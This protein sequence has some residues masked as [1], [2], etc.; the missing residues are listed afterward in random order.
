VLIAYISTSC[1]GLCPA[2]FYLKFLLTEY[3]D[4]NFRIYF[5][6]LFVEGNA[7]NLGQFCFILVIVLFRCFSVV[8]DYQIDPREEIE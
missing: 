5:F 8:W 3:L 2:S 6:S 4:F 1:C 7:T